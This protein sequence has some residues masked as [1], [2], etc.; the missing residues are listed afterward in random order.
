MKYSDY[1]KT[2]EWK[3]RRETRLK[4]DDY[5]CRLCNSK[6]NLQVHHRTYKRI[7]CEHINDLTTLCQPCHALYSIALKIVAPERGPGGDIVTFES[8][9]DSPT[10]LAIMAALARGATKDE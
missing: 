9:P 3:E 4:R 8:G 7:G 2:P 6:S 1:L 10:D 5:K